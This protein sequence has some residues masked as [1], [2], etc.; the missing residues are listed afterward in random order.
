MGQGTRPARHRRDDRRH[1]VLRPWRRCPGDTV[2]VLELRLQRGGGG[3]TPPGLPGGRG[4]RLAFATEGVSR[5]RRRRSQSRQ[6]DG[7]RTYFDKAPYPRRLWAHPCLRGPHGVVER[8]DRGERRTKRGDCRVTGRLET[9]DSTVL[10]TR[11]SAPVI[12]CNCPG[13]SL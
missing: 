11:L 7:T 8:H 2:R 4:A 13:V 3:R 9:R 6:Y 12:A 1:S 10:T 5:Y